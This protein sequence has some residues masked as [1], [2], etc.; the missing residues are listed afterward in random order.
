MVGNPLMRACLT[1]ATVL[2]GAL[3]LGAEPWS[4]SLGTCEGATYELQTAR[5]V[6][7]ESFFASKRDRSFRKADIPAEA[8]LAG[9]V[10]EFAPSTATCISSLADL[11][12]KDAANGRHR[13]ARWLKHRD[14]LIL[15]TRSYREQR[16]CSRLYNYAPV[17]YC[18]DIEAGPDRDRCESFFNRGHESQPESPILVLG[19]I[20]VGGCQQGFPSP[21]KLD[22]EVNELD[23]DVAKEP[24]EPPISR[25]HPSLRVEGAFIGTAAK[26]LFDLPFLRIMLVRHPWAPGGSL[27]YWYWKGAVQCD[28][29]WPDR[30]WLLTREGRWQ[31]TAA[32]DP[33]QDE[34]TDGSEPSDDD[35]AKDDDPPAERPSA[36]TGLKASTIETTAISLVWNL[37]VAGTSPVTGYTL[38]HRE[39]PAGGWQELTAAANALVL[40]ERKPD[41]SY[42]FKVSAASADGESD[43]SAVLQVKTLPEPLRPSAPTG[44]TCA[45]VNTAA[46]CGWTESAPNGANITGYTLEHREVPDGGWLDDTRSTTALAVSGLREGTLYEFR[47]RAESTAGHSLW[48]TRFRITTLT[49]PKPTQYTTTCPD[50]YWYINAPGIYDLRRCIRIGTVMASFVAGNVWVLD[51]FGQSIPDW[52]PVASADHPSVD[53]TRHLLERDGGTRLH[54]RCKSETYATP[55]QKPIGQSGKPS[56]PLSARAFWPYDDGEG[57]DWQDFDMGFGSWSDSYEAPAGVDHSTRPAI[58]AKTAPVVRAR[59]PD[60]TPDDHGEVSRPNP[61]SVGQRLIREAEWIGL[62]GLPIPVA[63]TS[64][65]TPAFPYRPWPVTLADCTTGTML[66]I[67]RDGNSLH[68]APTPDVYQRLFDMIGDQRKHWPR[69]ERASIA[70]LAV[71]EAA[72]QEGLA[73]HCADSLRQRDSKIGRSYRHRLWHVY[74]REIVH[75]P[76]RSENRRICSRTYRHVVPPEEGPATVLVTGWAW[77]GGCF[78]GRF[79]P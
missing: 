19:N 10:F 52:Y 16:V 20:G 51:Y 28:P 54:Y 31:K 61:K 32:P 11:D 33:P 75:R 23:T 76:V 79:S 50:G 60:R 73:E 24:D 14:E 45:V 46:E 15:Q 35:S 68:R 22:G 44:L 21:S 18:A 63:E 42:E 70:S 30:C 1:V 9:R 43:W 57:Y 48:S 26:T 47:V 59:T 34:T 58:T 62:D 13:R 41:T 56:S 69:P 38:A 27:P 37:A 12:A 40:G 8:G 64:D 49:K 2:L 7:Y 66:E 5:T 17:D 39:L 77:E 74:R 29:E 36:P 6:T 71:Y 72:P 55:I 3:S 78:V 4:S 25:E 67:V 65:L 53:C